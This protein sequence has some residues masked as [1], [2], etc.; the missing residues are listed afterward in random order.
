METEKLNTWE[1][2]SIWWKYEGK[3]IHTDFIYGVKNLVKWFKVV[4]KDRDYDDSFI[5]EVLKFKIENT[6]KFTERRK[7]FVGWEREVSRMRICVKLINAIQENYYGIEYFDYQE[8][9]YSFV[10]SDHLDE[11]GKGDYYT[12]NSEVISDNLDEYFKKYPRIYK[13]V[14]KECD[15]DRSRTG[16][17]LMVG[18]RNH[19]RAKNLLFKILNNHIESWWD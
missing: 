11:E 18:N 7:W 1:K 5:F 6:A 19:E 3:Y 4:W 9:E 16:I 12:L 8:S 13:E 17:A 10:K 2:L 14:L 15:E